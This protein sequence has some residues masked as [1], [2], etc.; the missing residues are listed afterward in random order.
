MI[1]QHCGVAVHEERRAM[2]IALRSGPVKADLLEPM[3]FP[4]H[5]GNRMNLTR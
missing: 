2:Q 4:Q 5:G 3:F 1:L